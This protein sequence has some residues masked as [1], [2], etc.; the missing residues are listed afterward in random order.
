ML[1]PIPVKYKKKRRGYYEQL[2]TNKLDNL[3]EMNTFL[4]THNLLGLIHEEIE[5]L[6][7]Q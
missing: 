6:T 5:N 2:S 7:N 1:K 4:E 3:Q